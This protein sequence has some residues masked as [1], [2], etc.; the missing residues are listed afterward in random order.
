MRFWFARNSEVPIREQIVT[1]IVL[2]ILS[3]ELKAG[4]RLPSTRELARRFKLHANTVSA[5][6]RQLER[7]RWVASRRG[8]GVY[9]R[10]GRPESALPPELEVDRLLAKLLHSAREMGAPLSTVHA[11]LRRWLALQPPDHFLLVEPD[12]ELRR[13]VAAEMQGAVKL[14]VRV[15]GINGS[16]VAAVLGGAI[17]VELSS[18][19]DTVRQALPA[20]T[21]LLTLQ[22]RS[23]PASLGEW[24]PAPANVLLGVASRWP[25]FLISAR[26]ILVA[27][28]FDSDSLIFL[29]ARES[30]WLDR[31]KSATAVVCDSV[32]AREVPKKCRAILFPLIAESSLR[33][34]QGYE[35]FITD[36]VEMRDR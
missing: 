20:G 26:T 12:E 28:G 33:E 10:K 27:A 3:D 23:V 36:P 29:D 6:Y 15:T 21:E 11:H 13:I 25:G 4:E 16:A 9:V 14:P 22:L 35:R 7:N 8:S 31:A 32:T 17:P 30:G 18:K 24:L 1:Q 5:A 34:L 19:H 2:G